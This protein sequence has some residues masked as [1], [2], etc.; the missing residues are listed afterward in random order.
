MKELEKIL[1][2]VETNGELI[3]TELALEAMRQ[4]YNLALESS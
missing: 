3:T 1:N 4:A 2:N